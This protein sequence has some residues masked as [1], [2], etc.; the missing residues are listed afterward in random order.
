MKTKYKEVVNRYPV[1]VADDGTE[2]PN[3]VSCLNYEKKQ[4]SE[5]QEMLKTAVKMRTADDEHAATLYNI[6]NEAQ[7]NFLCQYEW[8]NHYSPRRYPGPGHYLAIEYDGGDYVNDYT[9]TP[10]VE[11]AEENV[12]Q[13]EEY[14]E[15]IIRAIDDM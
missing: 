13:A 8:L 14:Y 6:K 10:A 11:Y 5:G 12:K 9:I 3:M 4:Y 1:Y 15:K 2:F 7:W